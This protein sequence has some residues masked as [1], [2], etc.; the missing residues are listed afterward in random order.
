MAGPTLKIEGLAEL[1]AALGGFSK[2]TARG[3][4]YRVLGKAAKPVDQ[5]WRDKAPVLKGGLK[6]SGA[7]KKATADVGDAAYAASMRAADTAGDKAAAVGAMRDALRA[8]AGERAFAEVVIGPGRHPKAVQQEFGN[9]NHP[10]QPFLRP[11]WDETKDQAL[12]IIAG[13]LGDEIARTAA[14]VA[15]KRAAKTAKA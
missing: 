15:K 12:G 8:T 13:E 9:V 6:R 3:T 1:D 7:V 5:A 4:L 14:R 2:A 10:P 11:A